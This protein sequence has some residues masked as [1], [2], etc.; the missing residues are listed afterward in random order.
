MKTTSAKKLSNKIKLNLRE[1]FWQVVGLGVLAGMRTFSAPVVAS[2]ILSRH[3]SKDL[4]E[5]PLKFMQSDTTSLVFKVLAVGELVGDKLPTTPNRTATPGVIGR[6][7]SGALAG[8]S[9]FKASRNNALA[10]AIIGSVAALGST[11]GCYYLRKFAGAKTGIIDPII[12]GIE[13]AL[14]AGAGACL[15]ITA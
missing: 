3:K 9:I 8:A 6:C 12:G 13:D 1:P 2:H 15:I 4:A 7:V 5:S 11:F 14:V 10:G